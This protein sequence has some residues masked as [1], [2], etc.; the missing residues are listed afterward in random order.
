MSLNAGDLKHMVYDI[1]EVDSFKSKMGDDNNITVV[2]FSVKENQ[3]AKDLMTFIEKGYP[4][5]LDADMTTGEQSD[6]TYKVFVELERNRDNP[7]Q[8]LEIIDGVQKL[9][10]LDSMKFRYYKNFRSTDA[11][12]E[13]LSE[14]LPLDRDSYDSK[15]QGMQMENY[16]NFFNKSYVE[17]IDMLDDIITLKKKYSE[18]IRLQFEDFGSINKYD[19]ITES[20]NFDDFA[21]VIFLSKYIGDYNIS[22]Y[23]NKFTLENDGKVLIVNR[24]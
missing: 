11:T 13:N 20:Y 21:E 2:S 7:E 4:F 22:K 23:G 19:E 10:D 17:S 6:G 1:F 18:P 8:I 24:K 9:S 15:I 5:V 12:S 3:V 16:Q 14:T